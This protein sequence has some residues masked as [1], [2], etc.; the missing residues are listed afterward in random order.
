MSRNSRRFAV[1]GGILYL[2]V[3]W[4]AYRWSKAQRYPDG[5]IFDHIENDRRR[6]LAAEAKPEPEPQTSAAERLSVGGP[7][8]IAVRYDARGT[9]GMAFRGSYTGIS[10]E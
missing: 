7:V 2:F 6:K 4:S 8:R 1:I 5:N 3:M 9:R 10:S